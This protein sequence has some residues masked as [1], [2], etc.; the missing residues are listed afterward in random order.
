[1][2]HSGKVYKIAGCIH[3]ININK[4]QRDYKKIFYGTWEEY[5][6]YITILGET[7]FFSTKD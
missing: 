7:L 2:S 3:Y 1:M 4:E 6:F 5:T